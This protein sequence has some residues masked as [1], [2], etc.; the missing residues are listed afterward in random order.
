M[1]GDEDRRHRF[2]KS[3][4]I[5]VHPRW[6]SAGKDWFEVT[7]T[8]EVTGPFDAAVPAHAPAALLRVASPFP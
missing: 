7:T 1:S 2:P 5:R 6:I 4:L 3:A 8:N